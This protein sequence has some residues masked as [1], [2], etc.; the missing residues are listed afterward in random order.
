MKDLT[1][2]KI[3]YIN[4][5]VRTDRKEKFESQAALAAM[6]PVERISG[7]HGL[8]LE[9]HSNKEIGLQTRV[10]LITEYRRSHYEI[11]SIGAIGASLSHI[12][13]WKA[14]LKTKAPYALILEDDADLPVT[15]AMMVRDSAKDLPANWDIWIIGWNSSPS[16]TTKTGSHPFRTVLHF[17]GAHCY[18]LSRKA[19]KLLVDEA[20][21]IETH[22][23]FFMNNVAFIHGLNIVRDIRLHMPQLNRIANI[24]DIRKPEGCTVCKVDDKEDLLEARRS[25]M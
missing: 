18:I 25:N 12:K 14:F 10:Q 15:F 2:T 17:T 22:I 11:H 3:Y 5:D 9:V 23:E 24:S 4:L 1:D 19:A 16:D 8:K 13:A 7:I 21:P 20:F 6:P